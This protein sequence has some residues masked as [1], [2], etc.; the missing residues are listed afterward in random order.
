MNETPVEGRHQM[1]RS[2]AH[3]I[4]WNAAAKWISQAVGWGS[5]LII[6]RLLTPYDYGIMGMA[7]LYLVLATMVSQ[8]GIGEAIVTLRDVSSRTIAQLNSTA[9]VI[10]ALLVC[11][12]AALAQPLAAFFSAPPLRDVVLV[13]SLTYLITAL[14]VVPRAL[15]QKEMDFKGLAAIETTRF[16]AQAIVS[17][18]LAWAG[19]H[20]WS[21]VIGYIAGVAM[22]TVLLCR[23]RS[24]AFAWPRLRELK[25][26][27]HYGGSVLVTGIAWYCYDNSDFL[28]AGRVLGS[29]PL[30]SYS[31]AWT[32]ACAP[33]EKIAN[34]ITGV[35]PS[36]FAAVQHDP[37]ELRRYLLG[38][39]EVIS[40]ATIPASLGLVLVADPMVRLLL[41]AKWAPA[42][43]PLQLL[44]AFVAARSITTVLPNLLISI[45]EAKFVM[46]STLAAA[47]VMPC[48]FYAGSHWGTA[49][50][51]ATWIA[52]Y[53]AVVAPLVV[54]VFRRTGIRARQ[55]WASIQPA[56][57]GSAAMA[58]AVLGIEQLIPPAFPLLRL[59]LM[60]G[61]GVLTYAAVLFGLRRQ[62]VL[63]LLQSLRR[64]KPVAPEYAAGGE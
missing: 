26:E 20:Y 62:R 52:I 9:L 34:L 30:G 37:G 64:S 42:I 15:L 53:P 36:Y 49:G 6:A 8:V 10:G 56:V 63:R 23:R 40:Y 18:V 32:I 22:A 58:V 4:A 14:Q 38:L 44:G 16:V 50:I 35:T 27:L 54:K 33:V 29:V 19:F 13:V 43:V 48:A 12:S 57:T 7:G 28:V 45:G 61:T 21:L 2:L 60:I 39:T 5:T 51:A 25:R 3:S 41:G 31:M 1:D 17:V 24:H 55:Y 47:V 46:W 11:I 59:V